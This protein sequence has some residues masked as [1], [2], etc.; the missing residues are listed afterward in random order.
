MART[1][2]SRRPAV[3]LFAALALMLTAAV[4]TADSFVITAPPRSVGLPDSE[5]E[6]VFFSYIVGVLLGE[7]ELDMDGSTLLDMFPE[8]SDGSGQVPFHQIKRVTRSR[9]ESSNSSLITLSFIEDVRYPVP[10]DILGYH[11][12]T[13]IFSRQIR[14]VESNIPPDLEGIEIVREVRVDSGTVGIDFDQWLDTL[15]GGWVDDVDARVL[16]V[17]RYRG[18]WYGLLGGD[19]PDGG[20]IT[21]V[22]DLR[23]SRI[24]VRPPAELRL[25]GQKLK[26]L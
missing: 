3:R 15:L 6:D 7:L 24:I 19:T 1:V 21:G 14:F 25:L 5:I 16:A 9:T 18:E 8:F 17:V 4:V 22:Y 11:P 12:G 10:V 20:W 2:S 13:V 26:P 23:N